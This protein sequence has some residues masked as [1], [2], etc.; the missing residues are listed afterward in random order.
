MRGQA[1]VRTKAGT[2]DLE[3]ATV[4][5]G[6]ARFEM[7]GPLGIRLG[8]L[9][10]GDRWIQSYAIRERVVVRFPT[11]ELSKDTLRRA[12]FFKLIPF[13]AD[14]DVVLDAIAGRVGLEGHEIAS[15]D[16]DEAKNAYLLRGPS[17]WVW[18]DPSTKAPLEMWWFSKPVPKDAVVTSLHPEWTVVYSKL[19]GQ[20]PSTFPSHL[21]FATGAGPEF[22]FE[23]VAGEAWDGGAAPGAFE[24][25]PPAGI[26]IRDY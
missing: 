15:C 12:R 3:L 5:T 13:K 2:A 25:T 9:V 20:G 21:E 11:S 10:L 8:L 19:T 24:W 6:R 22:A 7:T 14:P 1:W 18:V 4:G 16:Y 23:W 26:E 17:R